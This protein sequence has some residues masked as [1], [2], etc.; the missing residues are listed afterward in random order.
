MKERGWGVICHSGRLDSLVSFSI[1]EKHRG[2]YSIGQSFNAV[3][4]SYNNDI[5]NL[6]PLTI[7]KT[8]LEKDHLVYSIRHSFNNNNNIFITNTYDTINIPIPASVVLCR[9]LQISFE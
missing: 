3:L 9:L 4:I 1:S 2:L 5:V 7:T 8:K 6:V